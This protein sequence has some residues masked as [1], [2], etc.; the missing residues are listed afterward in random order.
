MRSQMLKR[1]FQKD[2]ERA[3]RDR[4][5]I[6]RP[7]GRSTTDPETFEVVPEMAPDA[8]YEGHAKF[9]RTGQGA[10][11][12]PE[13]G[14]YEFTVLQGRCD[15]PFGTDVRVDDQITCLESENPA[16]VGKVFRV[17]TNP[18][19]SYATATRVPVERHSE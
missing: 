10:N 16:L 3:M 18:P 1:R 14:G 12:N 13:S 17:T 5:R 19:D 6:E 9:Q 4:V 15:V 2:A 11:P 7:T 8:V